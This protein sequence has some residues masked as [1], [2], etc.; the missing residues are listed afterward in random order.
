MAELTDFTDACLS[1]E[2]GM[3]D[4][5]LRRFNRIVDRFFTGMQPVA[6]EKVIPG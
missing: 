6:V 3:D 5:R 1:P 4:T 2:V